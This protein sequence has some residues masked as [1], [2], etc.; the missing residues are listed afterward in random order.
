MGSKKLGPIDLPDQE[1]WDGWAN[2]VTEIGTANDKRMQGKANWDA[3]SPEFFEQLYSGDELASR[4]VNVVPEEALRRWVEWTGVEKDVALSVD[5]KCQELDLRGAI[6]RTW[7]W[8]RAYGGACLYIVTDT[9]DPAS[10]LREGE[11]VIGLRDLSRYDLRIL[12]TDVETDFGSP[13]WGRPNIYY[14][15]VQMGS[16]YKGYPIH[17][18][19]MVR[20][21]G[22]LVP[23]RT[24]IRNNYWHDSV[25]NRLH[26]SIRNYQTSNDA[27][28]SIL[29]DFN[30]G[31]Y[32]MKNLA[33]LMAAGKENV[34]KAR[35]EMLN[36]S[37]SI[38]RAMVLD[39]DEEEFEDMSRSVEGLA[40]LLT[41]QAN[42]LVAATDIPHTK[43]LG[44]SPDGSNATGNSTTNQWF[45]HIQSEQE[46]YLRPKLNHL[47]ETLFPDL[48]DLEHKFK[49]LYQLTDLEE[50]DRRNKQSIT[51][52]NYIEAGVLDP[53]EV[54]T[55][56]FGGDAYSVETKLDQEGRDAGLIGAGSQQ[57][58][59]LF[60][61]GEQQQQG[62]EDPNSL[63]A[64]AKKNNVP[65]ESQGQSKPGGDLTELARQNNV[66]MGG[67][68]K[69]QGGP[70]S[71]TELAKQN[72]V[73]VEHFG[74]S[75][76]AEQTGA[77]KE[78]MN[79]GTQFNFKNQGKPS[80]DKVQPFISQTMSEPMRDPKTDPQ[81]PPGGKPNQERVIEPEKGN[82]ITA[83][84]K[85]EKEEE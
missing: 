78:A 67:Q 55:S 61:G 33:N 32:K 10:P 54:A 12:T 22:Y 19:R 77:E 65:L 79:P 36:Y 27:A 81:M 63:T 58:G 84:S 76:E 80:K 74:P 60:P 25:L 35:I 47:I 31:I 59:D 62:Q 1:R 9:D 8:G 5:Q 30:V 7:K 11:N 45:D 51:D 21:D 13:N 71:L 73:P 85:N 39:A 83:S 29:Q 52:R 56:R 49:S 53:S 64:L 6:E 37:K 3:R 57:E 68:E 43:L 44:E 66:P 46:N 75:E 14:L 2:V 48:P 70:Q 26:N 16:E 82:G 24:Y 69:P 38:I 34:V 41:Q 23:R 40:E 17:W 50:A 42:R 4:I 15:V 18:T 28:A 72:N 20:F